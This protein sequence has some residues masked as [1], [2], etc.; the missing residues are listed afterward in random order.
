[1]LAEMHPLGQSFERNKGMKLFILGQSCVFPLM[2]A[3]Y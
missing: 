2:H 1:M 3:K